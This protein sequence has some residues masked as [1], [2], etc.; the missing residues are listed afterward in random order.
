MNDPILRLTEAMIRYDQGDPMRVHHFLKV[1]AFAS[2]IGTR[3]GLD[4]HTQFILEAA[5]LVHDIGVRLAVETYGSTSGRFQ[6]MVGPAEA[7]AMLRE[8]DFPEDV[9]ERVSY[10]VGH[11]HT[12]DRIDSPDYQILVEADFLVNLYEDNES[13]E[14]VA[15]VRR[16]IFKTATGTRLLDDLY[17]PERK[18]VLA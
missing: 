4:E 17:A 8:L 13:P 5:A 14:T 1:Y 2:A 10:L 18:Q 9:I 6:E 16:K 7:E 15:T 12:Y 3:E 11:H